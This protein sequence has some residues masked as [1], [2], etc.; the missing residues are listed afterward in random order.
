[1]Y[2][3]WNEYNKFVKISSW[4]SLFTMALG[5]PYNNEFALLLLAPSFVIKSQRKR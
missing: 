1:M 2:V 3:P 4:K 5:R